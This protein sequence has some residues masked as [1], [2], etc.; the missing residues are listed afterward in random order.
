MLN[1]HP[2]VSFGEPLG[3]VVIILR[4]QIWV[5]RTDDDFFLFL[6]FHFFFAVCVVCWR[7]EGGRACAR[8]ADMHGGRFESTHGGFSACHGTQHDHTTATATATASATTTLTH[9]TTTTTT[10]HNDTN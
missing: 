8:G 9:T 1:R 4:G 6:R 5:S 2:M 10:T 7:R 3:H